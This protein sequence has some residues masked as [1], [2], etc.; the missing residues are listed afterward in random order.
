VNSYIWKILVVYA[1][2]KFGELF[3]VHLIEKT[4]RTTE[5]KFRVLHTI[6]TLPKYEMPQLH[7]VVLFV[8]AENLF[9]L[10]INNEIV[11]VFKILM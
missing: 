10:V 5:N 6:F 2:C 3:N 7:Q 4:M 11:I 9:Y 8:A 1:G